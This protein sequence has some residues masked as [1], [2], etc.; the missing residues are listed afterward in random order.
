MISSSVADTGPVFGKILDSCERLFTTDQLGIFLVEGDDRVKTAEWRGSAL[1]GLR[2]HATMPLEGSF[3]GKAIRERQTIQVPD[4]EVLAPSIE[5]A[6][7][8]IALVGNYSAIYSPMLWEG[9][10]VGAICIFRQPPRPFSDKEAALLETFADQ[11]V[12]AIQNC[13]LFCEVRDA[14]AAAE[15]ANE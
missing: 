3:T 2:N 14:R 10:G 11:A 8:A 1:A 7:R 13:R 9:R 12:I 5:S 6:R 15:A 4:A